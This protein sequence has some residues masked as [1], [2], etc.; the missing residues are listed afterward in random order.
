MMSCTHQ[1]V[2]FSDGNI[3]WHWKLQTETYVM[4]WKVISM[5]F[6]LN[7]YLHHHQIVF[8]NKCS[9]PNTNRTIYDKTLIAVTLLCKNNTILPLIFF[10]A[11]IG[12][13]GLAVMGQN[14]ILNMND[15]GFVVCAFNR[16]PEK[17]TAFIDNEAKGTQVSIK[18]ECLFAWYRDGNKFVQVQ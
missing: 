1:F 15:H 11:D 5:H 16:S 2:V 4:C 9:I 10:R 14:L 12:L 18:I 3:H 17:V 6:M 7:W 13:I 8:A